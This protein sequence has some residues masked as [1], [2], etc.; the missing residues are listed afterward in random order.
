MLWKYIRNRVK[1]AVL[2]GLADG[3]AEAEGTGTDGLAEAVALYRAKVQALPAPVPGNALGTHQMAQD[4]PAGAAL[5]DGKAPTGRARQ[6][7]K[8]TA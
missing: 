1:E 2:A 7:A 6:R 5:G 8:E 4:E 3:L